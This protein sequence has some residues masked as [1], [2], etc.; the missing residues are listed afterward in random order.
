MLSEKGFNGCTKY[1]PMSAYATSAPVYGSKLF[2]TCTYKLSE[3][4]E[5]QRTLLQHDL[6]CCSRTWILIDQQNGFL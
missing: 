5:C 2:V 6:V 1:K 4:S 3:V